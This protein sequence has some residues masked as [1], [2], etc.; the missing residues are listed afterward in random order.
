MKIAILIR[1]IH[2]MEIYNSPLQHI[3][4]IKIDYSETLNSFNEMILNPLRAFGTVDVF[5]VTYKS[6]KLDDMILSYNATNKLIEFKGIIQDTDERT[7]EIVKTILD[8]LNMIDDSYDYLLITRFDL[9]YTS[10]IDLSEYKEKINIPYCE[11]YNPKS[12][13]NDNFFVLHKSVIEI[14]KK[15][16]HLLINGGKQII[17][18]THSQRKQFLLHNL[19]HVIN[20]VS[21]DEICYTNSPSFSIK[22]IKA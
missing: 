16:L 8:G 12:C 9:E 17:N 4:A 15:S 22:R 6:S 7:K 21:V 3:G 11:F 19:H 13:I 1:G 2:Y 20:T 5:T 10:K 18:D 14:F